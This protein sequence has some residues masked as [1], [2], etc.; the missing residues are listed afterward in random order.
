MKKGGILKGRGFTLVELLVVI[1]IIVVLIAML[2]PALAAA[3]RQAQQVQ[4][5]SNLRQLGQAMTMYTS[6][7][8]Y[9]PGLAVVDSDITGGAAS[10]WP[11]LLRKFLSHNQK[12]FYCPAQDPRC[13]WND[14]N[15][16]YVKY[17]REIHTNFGYD[18]GERLILGCSGSITED[19]VS[20][21]YPGTWFSYGYNGPG[22]NWIQ[23]QF[24][25]RSRG[26]GGVFYQRIDL[27]ERKWLVSKTN[28]RKASS[29]KSPS[30]FVIIADTTAD[31]DN[32]AGIL[33]MISGVPGFRI[34]VADVHRGGANVLF[35]DGHV[36]WHIQS[37]M[38]STWIPIREEAWKHRM[39][40]YDHKP[41]R[42]EWDN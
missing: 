6:Q 15:P 3:R 19:G 33:P 17:A 32:D 1:A 13:Q 16:G 12:V 35:L 34:H 30:E 31:S 9:F 11:V 38:I 22:A 20:T 2:L 25:P 23:S 24:D 36:E 41:A 8:Q 28:L 14:D 26:M 18:L 39:W 10:C 37:D 5:A 40:N 29:V 7:Y 42:P 27:E 21:Y 4:C